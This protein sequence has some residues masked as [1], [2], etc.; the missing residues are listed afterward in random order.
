MIHHQLLLPSF[1]PLSFQAEIS[2][3]R[4]YKRAGVEDHPSLPRSL[5]SRA[6]SSRVAQSSR[7]QHDLVQSSI[8]DN[9][10]AFGGGVLQSQQIEEEKLKEADG[11]SSSTNNSDDVTTALGL[12]KHNNNAYRSAPISPTQ[13]GLPAP[14]EEEGMLMNHSKQ[15][16]NSL[17][18]TCTTFFTTAGSSS[19]NA[20]DDLHKLVHY[21]QA[22]SMI[23]QQQQHY[24]NVHHHPYQ[25]PSLLPQSS[26]P[27][28]LNTLPNTLPNMLPAAFSDRLWE[29]NPIPEAN[30][31]Y[32][33]PF[34]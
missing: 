31:E 24:Y 22:S 34:K 15:A 33:N 9:F 26:Q 7:K 12:S 25:L 11:I 14:M 30:R 13:L 17:V 27:L 19:I 10:Q 2:L 1:P 18:P 6:S 4:V 23:G 16:C 28:S 8:L 5:P 29:W 20:V 21:Q 3:C 32:T